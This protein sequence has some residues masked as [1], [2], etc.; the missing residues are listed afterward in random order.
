MRPPGMTTRRW[1][2]LVA[3][4]AMTLAAIP[5]VAL[6]LRDARQRAADERWSDPLLRQQDAWERIDRE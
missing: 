6:L 1:I 3:L 5:I 2:L 4:T